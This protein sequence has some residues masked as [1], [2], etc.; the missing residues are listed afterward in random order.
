MTRSESPSISVC[1]RGFAGAEPEHTVVWVRGD[2]D[3][4]T[5]IDLAV[6]IA[7]AA[8]LDD[9]DVLLDLS[10]VTFMDASIVGAIVAAR[11]RLHW[12]AQALEIRAP[13]PAAR[14]I[15]DLCGLQHLVAAETGAAADGNTALG[16]WVEVPA[17]WPDE[18]SGDDAETTVRVEVDRVRS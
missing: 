2:H 13:A 5:K 6:A 15:L 11:N 9:A 16:S 10:C 18:V 1:R 17:T 4:T 3:S 7:R 14:R 12:R 8:Q